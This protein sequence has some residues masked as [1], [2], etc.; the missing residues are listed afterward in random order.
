MDEI[1]KHETNKRIQLQ[2]TKYWMNADIGH[3]ILKIAS[4]G[5]WWTILY[6]LCIFKILHH[7]FLK[8]PSYFC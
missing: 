2:R 6:I 1:D 7:N 4:E 8:V 5:I 3:E